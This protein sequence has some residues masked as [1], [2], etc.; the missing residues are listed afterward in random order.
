MATYVYRPDC[1]WANANGMVEKSTAQE[2]DYL[3]RSME[4]HEDK[5][6][7]IGN[8]P[9][10]F[11]FISDSMD[12]TRH[13]A[14]G[15]YYTSKSKFRKATKAAG[16]IEVG[17]ETEAITKPHKEKKLSKKE[18]IEHIKRAIE[19]TKSGNGW[20]RE[21]FQREIFSKPEADLNKF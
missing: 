6:M 1:P 13:M 17:N 3:K 18:R 12:E 10:T 14:N 11:R 16:C 4:G 9:V 8:E 20:N 19:E 15:K 21:R 5:R 7:M 2:Y